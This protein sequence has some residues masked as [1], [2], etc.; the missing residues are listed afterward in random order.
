L[1]YYFIVYFVAVAHI[2]NAEVGAGTKIIVNVIIHVV[3]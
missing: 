2:I 1:E 3:E